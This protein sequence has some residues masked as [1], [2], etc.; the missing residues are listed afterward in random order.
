MIPETVKVA[1]TQA[2]DTVAIMSFITL[3]RGDMLPFGAEWADKAGAIWMREPTPA[4]LE[5]EIGRTAGL[6]R[7]VK[8]YRI[9]AEAEVPTDRTFRNALRDRGGKL[10][11]DMPEARKIHLDRIRVARVAKLTELDGEWMRATGQG[12]KAEADA[13]EVQRQKLRDLPATLGAEAA[14]TPEELKAL[15]PEAELGMKIE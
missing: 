12:K 6:A 1:I 3:G 10:E 13:V 4:N 14:R 8:G 9:V 2:D 11:V 7:P 15:W 5:H